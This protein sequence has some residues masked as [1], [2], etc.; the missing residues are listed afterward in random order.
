MPPLDCT[1][2]AKVPRLLEDVGLLVLVLGL[3]KDMDDHQTNAHCSA[4]RRDSEQRSH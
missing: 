4:A 2:E 3:V 1:E